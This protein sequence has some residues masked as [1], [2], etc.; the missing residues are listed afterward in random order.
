MTSSTLLMTPKT[1]YNQKSLM[2]N[3]YSYGDHV[4][5]AITPWGP[6]KLRPWRVWQL[7]RM[8]PLTISKYLAE[9]K[10]RFYPFDDIISVRKASMVRLPILE[11][12]TPAK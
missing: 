4:F 5:Y 1:F 2:T 8:S 11:T 12:D 3:I 6:D 9:S 10:I 7:D